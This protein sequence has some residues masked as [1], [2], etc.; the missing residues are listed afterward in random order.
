MTLINIFV[1]VIVLV[2]ICNVYG[3]SSNTLIQT[4]KLNRNNNNRVLSMLNMNNI[5]VNF[6]SKYSV[7]LSKIESSK[8]VPDD[9]VYGQV[10][11]PGWVL[12]VAAVAII[13]FAAVPFLLTSGEKALE[14]QRIDEETTNSQFG[15]K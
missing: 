8:T 10:N 5:D 3:F 12:P 13:A 15:K 2:F 1:V 9:Y 7:L 14:Q 6:V 4:K 11:A